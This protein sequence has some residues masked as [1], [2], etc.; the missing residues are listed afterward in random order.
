MDTMGICVLWDNPV[1]ELAF[2][3]YC[4]HTSTRGELQERVLVLW[5]RYP[6]AA[7]VR[8]IGR[9]IKALVPHD[10]CIG[11]CCEAVEHR[12]VSVPNP[13]MDCDAPRRVGGAH[14]IPDIK[15]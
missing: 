3:P 5:Y 2:N 11:R 14:E 7:R 4:L 15:C 10:H 12:F 1:N 13:H 6:S 9:V 8:H